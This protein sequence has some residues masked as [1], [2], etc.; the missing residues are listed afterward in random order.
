MEI[1]P[2]GM[3]LFD[4]LQPRTPERHMDKEISPSIIEWEYEYEKA[5]I[6][7][8][9]NAAAFSIVYPCAGARW[10]IRLTSMYGQII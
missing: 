9:I 8:R 1:E 5:Q 2:F 6:L 4:A 10:N 7:T 3:A